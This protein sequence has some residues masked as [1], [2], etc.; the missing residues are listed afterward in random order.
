[1][2]SLHLAWFSFGAG[3]GPAFWLWE[4]LAETG[5]VATISACEIGRIWG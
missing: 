3:R 4:I 1:M 5:F 2:P